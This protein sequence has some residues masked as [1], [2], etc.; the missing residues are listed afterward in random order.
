MFP[1]LPWPIPYLS[2]SASPLPG[3]LSVSLARDIFLGRAAPDEP[4]QAAAA[5]A[6]EGGGEGEGEGAGVLV[7]NFDGLYAAADIA[8][9]A[10]VLTEAEMPECELPRVAHDPS[11]AVAAP[12]HSQTSTRPSPGLAGAALGS[13]ALS[14]G[15][16][17]GGAWRP[18]AWALHSLCER[19]GPSPCLGWSSPA[20]RVQGGRSPAH[21]SH[22]LSGG[23]S[24]GLSIQELPDGTMALVALRDI[25]AGE[26]FSL[27]PSDSEGEE[28][29]EEGEEEDDDDEEEEEE[30]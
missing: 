23:L 7:D 10:V 6:G 17:R 2:P 14:G 18:S 25:A 4:D 13:C 9:G 22:G 16:W 24:G 5:A 20:R 11:C 29:E 30:R 15:G 19:W 28:E 21:W 3:G 1:L 12:Q 8:Q 27:A 26:N